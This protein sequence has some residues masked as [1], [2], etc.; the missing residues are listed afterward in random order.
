MK[1]HNT[2]L[3]EQ[4][5]KKIKDKQISYN[6]VIRESIND[7]FLVAVLK[8][9]NIQPEKDEFQQYL[10]DKGQSYELEVI[11]YIQNN[12]HP[13]VSVEDKINIESC[14]K[15]LELIKSKTPFIHSAKFCTNSRTGEIDLLVLSSHMHLLD[16]TIAI[17]RN[18]EP[19]YIV[20]EIKNFKL[21]KIKNTNWIRNSQNISAA[22][23]QCYYYIKM[24]SSVLTNNHY[25]A[26]I[27]PGPNPEQGIKNIGEID[28]EGIDYDYI[29]QVNLAEKAAKELNK[30]YN[31][32]DLDNIKD[33]PYLYPNMKCNSIGYN[34]IKQK[35]AIDLGE[36]TLISGVSQQAKRKAHNKGIY[37]FKD[38]KYTPEQIVIS[39]GYEK[40]KCFNRIKNIILVNRNNP[41]ELITWKNKE[42]NCNPFQDYKNQD[43]IFLD[44]ETLNDKIFLS[45]FYYKNLEAWEFYKYISEDIN[46]FSET[47]LLEDFHKI[48]KKL[49]NPSI[50]YWSADYQ[51]YKRACKRSNIE[52]VIDKEKWVDMCNIF[53]K[54]DVAV[55][56]C[57]DYK[58]KRI[59]N[60]MTK[61][62]LITCVN[63]GTCSNGT[64]AIT[65]ATSLYN[66]NTSSEDKR[67]L[68]ES[69]I[70][71]N[72]LDCFMI[73]EIFN[74]F[75]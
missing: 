62:G 11:K 17:D 47:M 52:N 67:N 21:D 42:I 28:Y 53:I 30:G 29:R 64:D 63:N 14:E 58:L 27:I 73:L 7:N 9:K 46:T 57:Y 4:P 45:G 33:K 18:Y 75:M 72:K 19:Y 41:I 59:S 12:I 38:S 48:Y 6:P 31:S 44:F 37:S 50:L 54:N 2:Q 55:K 10:C 22:K 43:K 20:F 71:Y 23:G 61:H 39:Y 36:H 51:I 40:S 56:D 35:I 25:K 60:A 24:L 1:R 32:I 5:A 8:K 3:S 70:E 69:I 65:Q 66:I 34:N 68:Q 13:V 26:Y 74:Y 16:S 49:G 15:T